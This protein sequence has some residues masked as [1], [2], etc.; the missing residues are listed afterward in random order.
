M[1]HAGT[2]M[3]ATNTGG[4]IISTIFT[5]LNTPTLKQNCTQAIMSKI[6]SGELKPGD[7]LPPERELAEMMGISRSSVNQSVLELESMG[8]L[9]IQP[10]RGTVVRDYRKYPTP[11]S[12][13]A[14]MSYDSVE[15]D[16]SIFSDMMDFY[17]GLPPAGGDGMRKACM[18]EYIRQHVCRDGGLH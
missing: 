18:R 8:F 16:H 17:D 7:R 11:Q 1:V 13:A 6:I 15:L 4:G 9:N 3:P 5:R 12:L 10:R 2:I 14:I